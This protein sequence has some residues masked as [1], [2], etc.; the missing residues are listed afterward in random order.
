MNYIS[1]IW[2]RVFDQAIYSSEWLNF[3]LRIRAG[4][5]PTYRKRSHRRHTF[6]NLIYYLP[7]SAHRWYYFS[8]GTHRRSIINS[9]LL[10]T[11]CKNSNL[12][13]TCKQEG[14]PDNSAI[15]L[16]VHRRKIFRKSNIGF[17]SGTNLPFLS[18][19]SKL[20]V[21]VVYF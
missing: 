19:L 9:I 5:M 12:G 14:N 17:V 15:R 2:I 4:I 7:V 1:Y 10:L 3:I 13:Q 16:Q 18:L 8:D 11:I 21:R 6:A 20:C